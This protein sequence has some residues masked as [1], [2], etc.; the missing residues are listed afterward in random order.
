MAPKECV[1]VLYAIEGLMGRDGAG[2]GSAWMA[3]PPVLTSLAEAERV[4]SRDES[5]LKLILFF[6]AEVKP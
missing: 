3:R 2:L 6:D 1:G 4:R 5:R